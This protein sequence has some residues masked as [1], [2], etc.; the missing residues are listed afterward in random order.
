MFS[1]YERNYF[2]LVS[3]III[4]IISLSFLNEIKRIQSKNGLVSFQR[5]MIAGGFDAS[6]FAFFIFAENGKC[7]FI[8]RVAQNLFPGYRIR[9]IEDFIIC[10]SKYPQIVEAIT[11][12]K[13]SAGN[14]MQSHIDVPMDL[15]ADHFALW[16]ISVS[17]IPDRPGFTSWTIVDLTPSNNKIDSLETNGLF[18]LDVLNHSNQGYICLNEI[19]E[20]IFCNKTFSYILGEK[21]QSIVNNSLEKYIIKEKNFTED[22]PR[23][24]ENVPVKIKLKSCQKPVLWMVILKEKI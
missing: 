6:F 23:F 20:I 3:L 2:S 17:P 9:T 19:N 10:F 18:L 5:D 12:L 1:L 14:M 24:S 11:S 22:A 15:K 16:R 8:N 7:L 4:G 21:I 13:Q